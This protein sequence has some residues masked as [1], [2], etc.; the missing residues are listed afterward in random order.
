M[1]DVAPAAV[2]PPLAMP[3]DFARFLLHDPAEIR[4]VLAGLRDAATPLTIFAHD[5]EDHLPSLLLALSDDALILDVGHDAAL[6]ERIAAAA[7]HHCVGQLRQVR[8]QCLLGPFRRV[9]HAGRPAFASAL[10]REVLRLQR[11]A[12]YRLTA[13][14]APPL[15]CAL[16][17]PSQTDAQQTVSVGIYDIS[18]GG[19]CINLPPALAALTAGQQAACRIVLPEV[20][21]I[22]G[23]LAVCSVFD[24]TLRNGARVR[25]A[26][27][28]FV[29]L[30]DAQANLIQRY[31]VKVE[32]T[33]K[34]RTSG[35]G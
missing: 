11:R 24:L 28:A 6:N 15:G 13:P 27:C 10:P 32:R 30:A 12:F 16:T 17:L 25:R 20:G 22:D 18:L 26:G 4:L 7:T 34:A 35:L 14:V 9:L 1:P 2:P 19:V 8:I 29:G 5:G 3:A 23:T 21:A 31:I 33:R